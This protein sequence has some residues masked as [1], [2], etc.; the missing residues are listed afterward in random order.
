MDLFCYFE[1]VTGYRAQASNK[2]LNIVA[3]MEEIIKLMQTNPA[4]YS[5]K[6]Q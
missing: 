6:C 3:A 5:R 1:Y 2:E 4:L